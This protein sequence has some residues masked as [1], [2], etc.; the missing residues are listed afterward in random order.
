MT[1]ATYGRQS[2]SRMR[3]DVTCRAG[4]PRQTCKLAGLANRTKKTKMGY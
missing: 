4:R 2:V 1:D 3:W